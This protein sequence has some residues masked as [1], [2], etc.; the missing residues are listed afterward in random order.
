MRAIRDH[1]IIRPDPEPERAGSILLAPTGTPQQTGRVVAVGPGV[2]SHGH[3]VPTGLAVGDHV[4][5][6]RHVGQS[7]E[8]DGEQLI[9]MRADDV[10]CVIE[11]EPPAAR[12]FQAAVSALLQGAE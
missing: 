6:G 2:Y 3:L 7:M 10:V 11:D 8:I 5:F 12:E 9:V 4:Q 1:V